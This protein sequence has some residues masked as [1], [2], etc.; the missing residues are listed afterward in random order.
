MMDWLF[1]SHELLCITELALVEF[2]RRKDHNTFPESLKPVK[3]PITRGE[4][5][6]GAGSQRSN[7]AAWVILTR[8][9]PFLKIT[10]C[11]SMPA[12]TI[13]CLHY[14]SPLATWPHLI[15]AT[16]GTSPPR[17]PAV[18]AGL[19]A[20]LAAT[21]S[22]PVT[23]SGQLQ[24]SSRSAWQS[25]VLGKG[26]QLPPNGSFHPLPRRGP[27]GGCRALPP[28]PAASPLLPDKQVT[29]LVMVMWKYFRGIL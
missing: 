29:L 1:A 4:A 2:I 22:R 13:L 3:R 5:I 20:L 17:A 24:R 11:A 26:C 8:S 6:A 14:N 7:A 15:K 27:C 18:G 25:K 28:P 10:P 21:I 23:F 9:S 12:L 16:R 19:T